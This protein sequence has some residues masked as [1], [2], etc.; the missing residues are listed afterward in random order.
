MYIHAVGI[1]SIRNFRYTPGYTF[2]VFFSIRHSPLMSVVGSLLDSSC[3][4]PRC[5]GV[6]N[7]LLDG[8]AAASFL[9]GVMLWSWRGKWKAVELGHE[10]GGGLR[11]RCSCTCASVRGSASPNSWKRTNTGMY[12]VY[13]W[14]RRWGRCFLLREPN[15]CRCPP[16]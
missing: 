12:W 6:F 11:T 14:V 8:G 10:A 15:T 16:A 13:H 4:L 7:G 3:S 9:L 2:C 1:P 5:D